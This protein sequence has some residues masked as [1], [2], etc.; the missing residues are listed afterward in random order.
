MMRFGQRRATLADTLLTFSRVGDT[1]AMPAETTPHLITAEELLGLYLPGK[2]AELVRGHLVV[3]EPPSPRHGA[4]AARLAYLL[5]DHVQRHRLGTVVVDAG[6]RIE[7]DPDT[8]RAP[9]VAFIDRSR[10]SQLPAA[11]YAPFAPDFAIEVVSPGDRAGELL[12]KVGQWLDAGTTL[13]WLIPRRPGPP[14]IATTVRC[15]SSSPTAG[16]MVRRSS[17]GSRA[18]RPTSC[19]SGRPHQPVF[20]LGTA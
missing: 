9:D 3:R 8:V 2:S 11:G 7:S 10:A 14:F 1:M 18:R 12:A 16:S 20:S 19:T 15:R 4:V 5:S 13:V 17:R 6:F